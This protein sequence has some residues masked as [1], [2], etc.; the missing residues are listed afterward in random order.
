MTGTVLTIMFLWLVVLTAVAIASG[1]R[2]HLRVVKTERQN[3]H[4]SRA[5]DQTLVTQRPGVR[6]ISDSSTAP[7][8]VRERLR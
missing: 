5:E 3:G 8:I 1:K 6:K 4:E 2:S 7:T